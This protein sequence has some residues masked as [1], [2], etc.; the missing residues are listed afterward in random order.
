MILFPRCEE[1]D[2]EISDDALTVLTRI[3]VE[4][5]LRYSIQLISTASLVCRKRKV[6]T[7]ISFRVSSTAYGSLKTGL[8]TYLKEGIDKLKCN[9]SSC[10]KKQKPEASSHFQID[11]FHFLVFNHFHL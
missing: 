1:E 8:R 6:S 9:T 7:F 5:S 3:G 11:F 4:T 2:V 10:V